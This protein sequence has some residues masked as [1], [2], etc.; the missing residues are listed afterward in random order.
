MSA[1]HSAID[2]DYA[3]GMEGTDSHSMVILETL[4]LLVAVPLT[5]RSQEPLLV[6]MLRTE[7]LAVVASRTLC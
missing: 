5:N 7:T 2:Y 4:R 3:A 6:A 1:D